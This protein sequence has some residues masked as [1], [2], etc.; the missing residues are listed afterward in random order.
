MAR[1]EILLLLYIIFHEAIKLGCNFSQCTFLLLI[2]SI[3]MP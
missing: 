2:R 3:F 1:R